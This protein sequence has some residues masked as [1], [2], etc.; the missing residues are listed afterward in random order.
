M[1]NEL[2]ISIE[3]YSEDKALT[4]ANLSRS[5]ARIEIA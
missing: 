3:P 2:A 5:G 1:F 4:T